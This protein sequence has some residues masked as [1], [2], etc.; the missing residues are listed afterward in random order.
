MNNSPFEIIYQKFLN[1]TCSD[2]EIDILFDHFGI[3]N[4]HELKGLIL[5]ELELSD[6]DTSCT[7]DEADRLGAVF[8][9]IKNVTHP[10]KAHYRTISSSLFSKLSVAAMVVVCLAFGI[11]FYRASK[12]ESAK[13]VLAT[14]TT[15]DVGPGGIKAVLTL[16]DGKKISLDKANAGEIANQNGIS[17][18]KNS[19]GQIVYMVTA[20]ATDEAPVISYNTIETPNGGQYQV[21][22][23]DGTRVWLNA[24]SSLKYPTQ[25]SGSEREVTLSGEA[26]FEVAKNR[27]KPFRV[28]SKEQEIEVLGTH[29]NVNSYQ[30]EDGIKTTLLE[31][32]V[33]VLSK[34][35]NQARLLLPGQQSVVKETAFLIREV[36]TEDAVAWKEG[37]F[38]FNEADLKSVMRELARWYDVKVRYEGNIQP[39]RFGGAIQRNLSLSQALKILEKSQVHFKIHGKEVIVMP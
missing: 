37:L 1:G 20:K 4:E 38:Q 31:G 29:F 21:V 10:E 32:S 18:S 27:K 17:I 8:T 24:A 2:E 23:P 26:Y 35:N 3:A 7:Q 33:K 22:L 16:S 5:Q 25:F 12:M 6:Q 39:L 9:R 19:E 36:N 13:K 14:H 11:W 30:Y 15:N 28:K 34:Q